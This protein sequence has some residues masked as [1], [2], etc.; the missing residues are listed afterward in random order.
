VETAVKG[1]TLSQV[2]SSRSIGSNLLIL[3]RSAAYRTGYPSIGTDDRSPI[4]FR[5][6]V[7]DLVLLTV[8]SCPFY[9]VTPSRLALMQDAADGSR[10]ASSCVTTTRNGGKWLR[11]VAQT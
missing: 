6:H 5:I 4:C 1:G 9:G 3:F 11:T 8:L 10:A 7:P 2:N